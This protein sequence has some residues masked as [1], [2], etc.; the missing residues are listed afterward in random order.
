MPT[1]VTNKCCICGSDFTTTFKKR[2]QKTCSKSCSYKLRQETRQTQHEPTKKFCIS[3]NQEFDDISKKKLVKKC[4]ECIIKE[5][6]AKRMERGSYARTTEQNNKL[7]ESL[8]EK[9]AAGWNPN[10]P[11][12]KEKLSHLMKE[13]WETGKMDE[14]TKI[15]CQEKY[16]ADHWTKSNV[17]K[18]VLSSLSKGRKFSDIARRNMS[19]GHAR[20]ILA[21]RKCYTRGRGG[22]RSDIGFYVRSRWEANFARICIY[23]KWQFKYEPC[24]FDL[25]NYKFYI[26]DFVIEETF[27]E[28]KGFMNEESKARLDDFKKMYPNIE[29]KIIGP[30]EYNELKLKYK[31]LI[32][33]EE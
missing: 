16:G 30:K 18:K 25:G 31:Q 10:T 27:Y 28:L 22:I 3:C 12:H 19:A 32:N 13:R 4:D 2:N 17:G 1:L 21:G 20:S 6:V 7:S 26:P 14:M 11:E 33:W 8:K 24:S 23:E 15:R 29:L 9:Y 5:G